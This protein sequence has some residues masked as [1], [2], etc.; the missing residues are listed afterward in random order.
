MV[1]TE[2][3]FTFIFAIMIFVG[4]IHLLYNI[5]AHTESRIWE[6]V[7]TILII[8]GGM[9]FNYPEEYMWFMETYLKIIIE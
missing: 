3:G 4:V 7:D 2:S 5:L 8:L 9:A 1:I 6:T